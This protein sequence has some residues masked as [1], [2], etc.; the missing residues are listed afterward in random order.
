[1]EFSL[2]L[3]AAS[4]VRDE[5][6][7]YLWYK[8]A[9]RRG[10]QECLKTRVMTENKIN[11]SKARVIAV[12]TGLF[13]RSGLRAVRMDDV[14]HECGIS[15]RTLYELFEDRES[16]I[17]ACLEEVCRVL[18]EEHKELIRG[19]ENVLHAFWLIFSQ[20][21]ES[22]AV[23]ST[24]VDELRRYYPK[25]FEHLIINVHEDM[26]LKT[27]EHLLKGVE[28]GLIMESL[29]I[30]FFSRAMT[31]YIYGLG[32]IQINTSTTGVVL[33]ERTIASAVA[34]FLRGISTE[35]GRRY[36]DE[37]ILKTL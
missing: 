25:A 29:E 11:D 2:Y 35:R 18:D 31:N 30:D 26:V 9:V 28:D 7:R 27:K 36:I 23:D 4:L 6:D 8:V 12:A 20:K 14:A 1:M 17:L 33:N 19:A 5:R 13:L 24:I 32:L 21:N 15:K 37:K 34:I 22:C 10:A 16:L 3:C